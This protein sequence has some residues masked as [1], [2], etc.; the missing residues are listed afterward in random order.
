[1]RYGI[2]MSALVFVFTKL[3]TKHFQ[4]DWVCVLFIKFLSTVGATPIAP[5]NRFL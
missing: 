2:C 4:N 5:L 1:M 3:H